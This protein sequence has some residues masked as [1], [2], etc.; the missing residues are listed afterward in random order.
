MKKTRH[1]NKIFKRVVSMATALVLLSGN[2]PMQEIGNTFKLIDFSRFEITAKAEPTYDTSKFE[3]TDGDNLVSTVN[4]MTM[5]N[6]TF[7]EY[8]RCYH[9]DS[10]FASRH[11]S[12][13]ITLAPTG[14]WKLQNSGEQYYSL[15]T[16]DYPF[17]GT[18]RV[19]AMSSTSI[20]LIMDTAFFDVVYDTVQIY[21]GE[22]SNNYQFEFIKTANNE[23]SLMANEVRHSGDGGAVWNAKLSGSTISEFIDGSQR[24]YGNSYQYGGVIGKMNDGAVLTLS[25]TDDTTSAQASVKRSTAQGILCGEM[26]SGSSLTAS[27]T[28]STSRVIGVGDGS[29][30]NSGGLVGTMTGANFTLTSASGLN[31][32]VKSGNKNAGLLVG[33][34]VKDVSN[35][36]SS[37]SLP[38]GLTVSGSATGS[39]EKVGG[40]VGSL[41]GSDIT[42]ADNHT[43]TLSGVTVTGG[44]KVGGIIGNF[45]PSA[46]NSKALTENVYTLT[47]CSIGGSAPGGIIGEYTS[48]GGE[49]VDVSHFTF[50]G[51]TMS[52]GN[53]GGVFGK[54]TAAGDTTI[55]GTFSAPS[56][57]THFGGVIGE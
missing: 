17:A 35:N 55:T 52:S 34:A 53:A 45:E 23:N 27:Y 32:D 6:N 36:P 38:D 47:N 57:S 12:D 11:S 43:I 33:Y 9:F 25:F 21:Q 15:G 48:V 39:G 54:Y 1:S 42:I 16:P 51:T 24:T 28:N 46:N 30:S 5:D 19:N 2:L 31:F 8:S 13:I 26:A 3:G 50:T 29:N 18:I 49:S 56:A 4:S 41:Q 7:A 44:N 14:Y 10:G 40:L 22:T 37:I 20:Q